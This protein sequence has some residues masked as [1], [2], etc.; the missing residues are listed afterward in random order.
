MHVGIAYLRWRGKRSRHSRRMR[1]RNF[2]YLAR[3]PCDVILTILCCRTNV[4]CCWN[5]HDNGGS[6]HVFLQNFKIFYLK[7]HTKNAKLHIA[8]ILVALPTNLCG[9]ASVSLQWRHNEPDGVSNHQPRNCLLNR[10]YRHRSKKTSKLRVTGLCEGNS[11]V[12][13]EFP[14]QRASNAENVSIWWRHHVKTGA[15][16]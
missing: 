10:L 14:A 7:F 15:T 13:G 5:N 9:V 1:T 6:N 12:I 8:Y 2:T 4:A 3:G 11:P 16:R